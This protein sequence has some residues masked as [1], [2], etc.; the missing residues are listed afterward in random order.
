MQFPLPLINS[1]EL[2]AT[3]KSETVVLADCRFDLA[4]P[5]WGR[6]AYLRAHIPGAVYFHL[7]EDLS[8]PIGPHGGRHPLPDPAML[9]AKL[10]AA[11]LGPGVP[12]VAYDNNGAFAAR[13]W[14]LLR[15][16]GHDQVTVL[17]GGFQ[18]WVEAGLPVTAERP[19]P[20]PR[21]CV[22][23][24]RPDM[25][26]GMLTVRDRSADVVVVDARSPARFAG[27]P[28]PLDPWPGHV[29][30]AVNRFWQ[31]GL[32]PDGTWKSPEEQAARF[33]DLPSG[34]RVIHQC[35]SGVTACANLLAIAIAGLPD[36]RLYP[37]SWSDWCTYPGN[38][39]EKA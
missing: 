28:N 31:E 24:P 18:A 16:L 29:P 20:A 7:D 3:L 17:D 33:A 25:I 5:G 38:P 23:H 6:Q 12:V 10:G 4:N 35:G 36:S 39:V 14:W 22:P 19:Q 8:A 30:G 2:T 37:G 1:A 11:G 27:E 34:E 15:W 32:R 26:A 21:Q 13:F 9:A